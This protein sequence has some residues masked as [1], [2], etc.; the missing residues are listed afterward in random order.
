MG[1]NKSE[2]ELV[3]KIDAQNLAVKTRKNFI[4]ERDESKEELCEDGSLVGRSVEYKTITNPD[5]STY[6]AKSVVR[7]WCSAEALFYSKFKS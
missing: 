1:Y 4:R 5:E 2:S 7:Y 6:Q 3:G